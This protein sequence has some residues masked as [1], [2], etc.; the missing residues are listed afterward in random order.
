MH[1]E[2]EA[3]GLL[4][5]EDDQINKCYDALKMMANDESLTDEM[6]VEQ[7]F[8]LITNLEKESYGNKALEELFKE[9]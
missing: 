1:E 8:E 3:E 4:E 2:I 9:D 5:K 6:L 7:V